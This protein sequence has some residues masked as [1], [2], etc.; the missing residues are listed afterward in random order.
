MIVYM[1]VFKIGVVKRILEYL[2]WYYKMFIIN[3]GMLWNSG[4]K[5]RMENEIKFI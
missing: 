1:F 3:N 2:Y 4:M 5:N